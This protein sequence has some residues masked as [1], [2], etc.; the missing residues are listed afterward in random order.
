[1]DRTLLGAT[2]LSLLKTGVMGYRR[3]VGEACGREDGVWPD[4]THFSSSGLGG[5]SIMRYSLQGRGQGQRLPGSVPDSPL[6][7][8]PPCT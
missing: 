6:P 2:G 1:M 3:G 8:N 7:A 5:I 4:S